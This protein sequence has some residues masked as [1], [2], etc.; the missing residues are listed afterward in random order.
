MKRQN[1]LAFAKTWLMERFVEKPTGF[2]LDGVPVNLDALMQ[3]ANAVVKAN[4]AEQ[5]GHN[6]RWLV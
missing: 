4:G 5:L 3:A 6:P 2:W 1:P